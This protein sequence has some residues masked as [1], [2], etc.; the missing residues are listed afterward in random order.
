L[1]AIKVNL[2]LRANVKVET[3]KKIPLD[4]VVITIV[5]GRR[6]QQVVV[7]DERLYTVNAMVGGT[8][9]ESLVGGNFKNPEYAGKLGV[10]VKQGKGYQGG[11]TLFQKGN[12][13]EKKVFE[14][15]DTTVEYTQ[16]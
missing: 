7:P 11:R 16:D 12:Y 4:I 6:V 5:G 13:G 14:M 2:P 3:E 9:Y 8:D 10:V 15:P 1:G